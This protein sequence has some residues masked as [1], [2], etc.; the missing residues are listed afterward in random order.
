MQT[1]NPNIDIFK[2]LESARRAFN[3]S[4]VA[5][6]LL[7]SQ[8]AGQGIWFVDRSKEAIIEWPKHYILLD[9]K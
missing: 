1:V 3:R 8:F 9:E 5:C 4:K 6:Q 2:T 7:E